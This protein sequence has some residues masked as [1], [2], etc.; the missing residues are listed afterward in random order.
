MNK[1]QVKNLIPY[2]Y[3][4]SGHQYYYYKTWGFQI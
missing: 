3:V 1:A 2:I 4:I